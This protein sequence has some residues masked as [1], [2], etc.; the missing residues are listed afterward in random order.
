MSLLSM[1]RLRNCL[2][3]IVPAGIATCDPNGMP[4]VTYISQLMYVDDVH[5]AL[6]FQFFNKTRENI[7]ANPVATVLMMDPD[8]AARYRL[9]IRYLRT[10]TAGPLFE[11]MKAKLAG[12]ASH[13][14]M[15]GVFRLRGADIY[16]VL[17]IESVPG[18][19]LP[20]APL[21]PAALPALRRSAD[22]LAT[23]NSI[24]ALVDT[25]QS[26]L[27]RH[28]GIEHQS[29]LMADCAAERLCVIAS[30]G[31]ANSGAGAEI[32]FGD[33][34]VGVAAREG[35]PIRLMFPAVEYAYSRAVR[36]RIAPEDG[37][38]EPG[39]EIPLPGLVAPASQL[40][41]PLLAMGR[42]LGVLYVESRQLCRFNYD[43]EDALV[44]LCAQFSL[45]LRAL[46]AEPGD[47]TP[48]TAAPPGAVPDGQPLRVRHFARDDSVFFDDAY[49]IKGVAGAILKRLLEIYVDCGRTDFSNRELRL[50]PCLRL[51]DICDNLD[52]RLILLTRRLI[53]RS[54]DVRLEKTGRGRFRLQL[55]RPIQLEHG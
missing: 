14:G 20:S 15:V 28:F 7:L 12:I 45:A 47:E 35:T 23:C 50:D 52:T 19:T 48:V 26:A 51:P 2:E 17:D 55:N 53:D 5:I 6:S 32:A 4:N 36:D 41:V 10:E 40:A 30:R 8:T 46:Q 16:R 34:I 39:E 1:D 13:T 9:R 54:D 3:G 29:L 42:C 22:A 37:L 27:E 43:L 11:R 25:L 31:Y 49:L 18:R 44:T 21:T 33:G 38:P 24:D